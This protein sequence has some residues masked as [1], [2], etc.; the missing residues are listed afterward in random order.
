ME[1]E[2]FEENIEKSVNEIVRKHFVTLYK[3]ALGVIAV[4]AVIGISLKENIIYPIMENIYPAHRIA[5]KMPKEALC[6][7]LKL[8]LEEENEFFAE[9]I[10]H[11]LDRFF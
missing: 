4:L 7:K 6:N 10:F 5:E 3:R 8:F 2:N 9:N 1:E 11:S